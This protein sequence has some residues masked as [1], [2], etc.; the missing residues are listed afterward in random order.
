MATEQSLDQIDLLT[1][2]LQEL[3]ASTGSELTRFT[4]TPYFTEGYLTRVEMSLKFD[5]MLEEE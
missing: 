2:M 5:P 1:A 3:Q 4:F